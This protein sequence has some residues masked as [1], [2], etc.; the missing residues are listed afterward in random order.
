MHSQPV[1]A[2]D[3]LGSAHPTDAIVSIIGVLFLFLTPGLS[4]QGRGANPDDVGSIDGIIAAFYDV[5]SVEA[6][7][8]PDWTRDSTLYL[9]GVRFVPLRRTPEGTRVANVISHAQFAASSEGFLAQ[10]FVEREIHRVTQRFGDLAHVF[11]TY[12]YRRTLD[13]P[14]LGRGINSIH[15]FFD[16]D[17]WW[18]TGAT[19]MDESPEQPIPEEYLPQ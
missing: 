7:E 9:P 12:E 11:S 6:G 2:P 16:G 4:A 19:W 10:G 5:I 13:T 3:G 8:K 1:H 17:R 18:I 14:V 15:L